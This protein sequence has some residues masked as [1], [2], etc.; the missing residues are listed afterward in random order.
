MTEALVLTYHAVETGP[1]PLCVEPKLFAKHLDVIG[2]SGLRVVTM[3][4]LTELVHAGPQGGPV[5]AITFDD[6]FAS[7]ARTA[8]PLLLE[9]GLR[10]TIFCVA[11]RLGGHSDWPTAHGSGFVGT[12]A[13]ATE[14]TELVGLGFEI[15]SHGFE[16]AP[17]V[18]GS[19][20]VLRRELVESRD[21]L[22]D[23][24]SSSVPTFALPYGA[25]PS[26]RARRMLE[27][28]YAAAC[29]TDLG[30]VRSNADVY[31]LPR[32]DSH[33]IRRPELLDRAVA[34][35]LDSYLRIRKAA[36]RVRRALRSDYLL[37][38]ADA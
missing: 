24:V 25:A 18:G 26:P 27:E 21:L 32:V 8:A 29:T 10:A 5:V 30:R 14:L 7:I 19:E 16:H 1:P 31:A 9:R 38:T 37:P 36:A 23:A 28:T 2:E 4:E 12:L 6:G 34:G 33:Y 35:R 22:E 15:G 13:T 11:G 3:A 17:L 20:A